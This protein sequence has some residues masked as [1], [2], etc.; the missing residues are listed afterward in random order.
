M[1]NGMSTRTEVCS[2]PS[3][4]ASPKGL[5]NRALTNHSGSRARHLSGRSQ[6]T[7]VP[8]M[9][10]E[11][12]P[13][14]TRVLR[15]AIVANPV[16]LGHPERF[17]AAVRAAMA[18]HG[19]SEP[20]WLETTP[21]DGGEA[22]ARQAV[23]AR[24]DLVIA[25]GGDGTVTAC[26]TGLV[27]SGVP[28]AVIP[29]G[30]GNIL[31]RNLGLPIAVRNALTV[32]LTGRDRELD[33]GIANGSPFLA[34]A[35]LGLDAAMLEDAT[36]PIKKR[37]GWGAYVAAGLRHLRDRPMLVCV[38]TDGDP[39]LS[40][41]ASSVIIGNVGALPG[42]LPLLP[43][44]RPDDGRLDVVVLTAR[45]WGSWLAVIM[46]VLRPGPRST[47]RVVRRP[48]R[49]LR[50]DTYGAHPWELDGEIKGR[51]RQLVITIKPAALLVRVPRRD[52]T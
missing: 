10:T 11:P 48:F 29:V 15:A 20:L 37:L 36:E 46:Q 16:K 45:S 3:A 30:T 1:L 49:E 27:D 40:R 14:R 39:P 21:A 33:V 28:L 51:T 31:A 17:K 52:L 18:E 4:E 7:A 24:A 13:G 47:G 9:T 35:G 32:A 41:R 43:D 34:M 38:R 23:Q 19:W 2:A 25:C 22:Q 8:N 50:I 12:A 42:G 5:L 6:E 44:A 26:A